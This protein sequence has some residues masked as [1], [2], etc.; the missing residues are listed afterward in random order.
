[1]RRL[2]LHAA[3]SGGCLKLAHPAK[4]CS[5]RSQGRVLRQADL[6][7][8]VQPIGQFCAIGLGAATEY[9]ARRTSQMRAG[10]SAAAV[11]KQATL[12]ERRERMWR[13]GARPLAPST[14]CLVGHS[15]VGVAH[16]WT[17]SRHGGIDVPQRGN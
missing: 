17:T 5:L 13:R 2:K 4:P 7:V 6:P 9:R 1:M 11:N 8:Q 12:C 15:W 14:P 10:M 3:L 16:S